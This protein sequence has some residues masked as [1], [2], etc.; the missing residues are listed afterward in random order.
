[1]E[2]VIDKINDFL[3]KQVE[4]KVPTITNKND[5]DE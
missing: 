1:L 4:L 2:D 5:K 3:Y